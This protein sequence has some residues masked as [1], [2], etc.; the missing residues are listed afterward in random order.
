MDTQ[1]ALEI[2]ITRQLELTDALVAYAE[3][4]FKL[5]ESKTVLMI[6]GVEGKNQA[7]RDA[8]LRDSLDTEYRVEHKASIQ[9]I[10]TKGKSNQWKR[11]GC[12]IVLTPPGNR[13]NVRAGKAMIRVNASFYCGHYDKSVEELHFHPECIDTEVRRRVVQF[14]KGNEAGR[15]T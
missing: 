12:D 1:K 15:N 13:L 10:K 9:V 2:F 14:F 6:Q 8:R 5:E 7:E 3:A 11:V 4:K